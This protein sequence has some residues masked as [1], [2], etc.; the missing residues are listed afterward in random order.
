MSYSYGEVTEA[1]TFDAETKKAVVGGLYC[2][3]IFGSLNCR[4]LSFD[5]GGV[6]EG[7]IETFQRSRFG[8]IQFVVPVVHT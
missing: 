8:H 1:K 6:E 5:Q 7:F 3:R 2:E 4:D